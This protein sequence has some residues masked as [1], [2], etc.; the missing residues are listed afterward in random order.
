[1]RF[2][3]TR[4]HMISALNMLS[5]FSISSKFNAELGFLEMLR[6]QGVAAAD[7]WLEEHFDH[8]GVRTTLDTKMVFAS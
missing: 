6:D 2:S 8:L 5:E 7:K 3:A 4:L 1:M